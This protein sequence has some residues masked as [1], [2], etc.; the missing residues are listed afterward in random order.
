MTVI[1]VF[2]GILLIP[3]LWFLSGFL[4]PLKPKNGRWYFISIFDKI[5]THIGG[6]SSFPL[7]PLPWPFRH[8]KIELTWTEYTQN[9][10][11]YQGGVRVYKNI[12]T[13][14]GTK[15][16]MTNIRYLEEHPIEV[17][18]ILKDGHQVVLI[19]DVTLTVEDP[20]KLIPR[21]GFLTFVQQEFGD[22]LLPWMK[23]NK[24]IESILELEIEELNQVEFDIA[25]KKWNIRSYLNEEKFKD[26]GFRISELSLKVGLT[27]ET[28]EFF[29]IKNR[30][31]KQ[32]AE[33]ALLEKTE[34]TKK[35]ERT[36]MKND[37]D[38]EREI[39]KKDLEV[40]AEYQ[41]SIIKQVYDGKKEEAA[42]YKA[43]VLVLGGNQDDNQDMV[44]AKSLTNAM[45]GNL[46]AHK[47]MEKKNEK[48]QQ[49]KQ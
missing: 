30:A 26:F 22:I 19:L 1:L 9:N 41:K 12:E 5:V 49:N 4:N 14:I 40:T 17:V 15:I 8:A 24:D 18:G 13:S 42:A 6:S 3:A 7:I 16:E 20:R 36:I 48:N 32:E 47:R 29:E 35:V 11:V 43:E 31:K 37:A 27:E 34:E 10:E 33:K 28:Y 39:Q 25:G 44:N 23:A 2:L 21:K 38:T 46:V 45:V